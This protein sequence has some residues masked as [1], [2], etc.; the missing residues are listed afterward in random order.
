MST[1][2]ARTDGAAV[3]CPTCD[4]KFGGM[5]VCPW[6]GAV[7]LPLPDADPT[8]LAFYAALA[9]EE[10]RPVLGDVPVENIDASLRFRASRP[11]V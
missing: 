2:R 1:R 7:L 5:S 10:G 8:A 4:A 3:Y 11:S 6:D 9:K